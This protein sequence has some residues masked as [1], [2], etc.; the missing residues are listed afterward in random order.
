MI[1]TKRG[2]DAGNSVKANFAD[3]YIAPDPRQY[4]KVLGDLDYSIPEAAHS[5]FSQ[6]ADYL[7][8]QK[9]RPITILDLGCSY[10]INAAL[11]KYRV[12]FKHLRQRYRWLARSSL[13]PARLAYHDKHYFEGWPA[14]KDVK[15]L[16]IDASK[17]A[18][19]YALGTGVLDGGIAADLETGALD[20]R[21]LSLVAEADLVI[22]TGCVGY[23]TGVTFEKLLAAFSNGGMPWVASFV[24]RVFPYDDIAARLARKGLVTERFAGA[25]FIQR[26]FRDE[27]EYEQMLAALHALG[28]DPAGKEAEGA[29]HA[30]LFVSRPPDICAPRNLNELLTVSYGRP[31]A[32]WPRPAGGQAPAAAA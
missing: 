30:E 16:G 21:A 13:P 17:A 1:I 3:A 27:S 24:L 14:R 8:V 4:F 25:T 18:I 10:G 26:R 23:V 28:L 19:D 11:L 9:K 29:L 20:A 32:A 7:I 15:I 31:G 5:I 12:P 6:L 22:S 2:Y